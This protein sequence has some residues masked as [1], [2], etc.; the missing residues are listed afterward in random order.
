MDAKLYEL[1]HST[2]DG[3][4]IWLYQIESPIGDFHIVDYERKDQS[5]KRTIFEEQRNRA[6]KKYTETVKKIAGGQL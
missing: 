2:V 5:I 3:R 6:E 4:N 1:A